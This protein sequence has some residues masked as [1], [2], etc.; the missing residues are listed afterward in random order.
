MLV[1]DTVET[2]AEGPRFD[3][4]SRPKDRRYRFGYLAY[5]LTLI[6]IP[7]LFLLSAIPIV[8]SAS[9]PADSADPFLLNPD[10]AASLKHAD[11]A[12]VVFGDSTAETGIDPTVVARTTGMKTCNI[13]QAQ[14]VIEIVGMAALN[15]YL[16]DNAPPK[17]IVFQFDPETLSRG[18]PNFFW[19]EGL[20]LLFRQQ[21]LSASLPVAIRHPIRFY[22]FALWAI[23]QKLLAQIHPPPAFASMQQEFRARQGLLTLPKPSESACLAHPQFFPPTASWIADL[24]RRYSRPGTRVFVDIAPVPQ[25]ESDAGRIAAAVSGVTDDSLSLYPIAD[26]NDLDRHLTLQGAQR[27]SLEISRQIER[28]EGAPPVTE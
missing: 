2:T 23:K 11:C 25:C 15:T 16:S 4:A 5:V 22:Q 27:R 7:A 24:R 6:A 9:F 12:V 13:S 17:V 10:Y 3:A 19:P 8:R 20:T 21:S 28:A 14:S 1:T 18:Y 26:F